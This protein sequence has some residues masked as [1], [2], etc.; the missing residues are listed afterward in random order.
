MHG[1]NVAHFWQQQSWMNGNSSIIWQPCKL[2]RLQLAN[3][4]AEEPWQASLRNSNADG[5]LSGGKER[6]ERHVTAERCSQMRMQFLY[7]HTPDPN[8]E[9][10]YE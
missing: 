9:Q 5:L 4:D 2:D 8:D 10:T 3:F 6:V 1:R 7:L